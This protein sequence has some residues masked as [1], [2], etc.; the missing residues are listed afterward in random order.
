MVNIDVNDKKSDG[1]DAI[2]VKVIAKTKLNGWKIY[3]CEKFVPVLLY[4]F[5]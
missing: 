4:Q 5:R 3:V 2:K 1:D